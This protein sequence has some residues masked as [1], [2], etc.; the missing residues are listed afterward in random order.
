VLSVGYVVDRF[1]QLSQTFVREEV[2][3]LRR[4][5]ARVSVVSLDDGDVLPAPD[6]VDDLLVVRSLRPRG[7]GSR[8]ATHG[9]R[10]RHPARA[11]RAERVVALLG[12]EVSGGEGHI[13]AWKLPA[14]GRWLASRRVTRLHA[15]FGWQGAGAAWVLSELMGVPWSVTLHAKDIFSRRVNLEAKLAGAHQLIT[16]CDYNRRYLRQDL[17][18]RRPVDV[19]VCGVDV[20]DVVAADRG[21]VVAAVGRLVPKK[22]FD[23]LIRAAASLRPQFPRLRVVIVGDGPEKYTLRALIDELGLGGTVELCGAV[24][25]DSALRMMGEARVFCLPA[26]IAPDGDRDSMPVVIKEAMARAV[27][28]VATDVVGIPE[29]VDQRCGRL[30]TPDHVD[31]LAEA[32]GEL[33]ADA[34]LA[35]RLGRAGR[36]RVMARC[37]LTGEV[38]KL[39]ALLSGQPSSW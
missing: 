13:P 8:V 23:V 35:R 39:M 33:L 16:V 3:E 37:T 29:I 20:P 10:V 6:E 9:E 32:I 15:H 22:G 25:H 27:P 5:G 4:L 26:R 12:D 11:R 14:V 7:L 31:G 21:Q 38:N 18:V 19:V 36:S 28:V 1:P 30:V 34:E 17:G 2:R 24:E